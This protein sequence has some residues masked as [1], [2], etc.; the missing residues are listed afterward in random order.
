VRKGDGPGLQYSNNQNQDKINEIPIRALGG[1]GVSFSFAR[2]GAMRMIRGVP[3]L[4]VSRF[5][6]VYLRLEDFSKS[7]LLSISSV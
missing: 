1:Y 4:E 7:R 6:E 5:L 3:S 2:A